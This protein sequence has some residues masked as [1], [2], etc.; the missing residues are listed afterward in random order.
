MKN[1]CFIWKGILLLV[2]VFLLTACNGET[3]SSDTT[4]KEAEAESISSSTS[5]QKPNA[6]ETRPAV[7]S[8]EMLTSKGNQTLEATL[9]Q[10]EGF[11]LYV[12]DKFTFDAT[13]NRLSLSGNPEYYVDIE[14]LPSAYDLAKLEVAGKEELLQFGEVSNF[15]GELLEHPLGFADLYLQVSGTKGISDY[16]VWT[17]ESG[18][19]FLFRL[20]NPKGEDVSDFAGPIQISLSTVQSE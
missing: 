12:F 19:A 3:K 20:H 2:L 13:E 8:F 15:S 5:G 16:I 4:K 11:S 18:D 6:L 17:A 1:L 14:P 9:H 7:K 10:G